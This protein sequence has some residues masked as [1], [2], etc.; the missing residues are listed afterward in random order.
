LGGL[1]VTRLKASQREKA[2]G[3]GLKGRLKG[4]RRI[5]GGFINRQ[6]N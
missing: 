3:R 2:S 6:G 4:L 1:E 5:G